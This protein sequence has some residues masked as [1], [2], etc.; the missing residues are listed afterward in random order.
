MKLKPLKWTG[1]SRK[2]FDEFPEDIQ[3]P[4]GFALYLAQKGEKHMHAKPLK[5]IGV[6]EI[7]ESDRNGTFR[8]MYTV[9]MK[10]AVYVLHA[11]QK[12]SK[13]GIATPR[14]EIDLVKRRLVEVRAL[15]KR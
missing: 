9:E 1:S 6:M 10:E 2:D 8:V 13:T 4:M 11:F 3:D 7:V 15:N 12:K 14:Q 5:G